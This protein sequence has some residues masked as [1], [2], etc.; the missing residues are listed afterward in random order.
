[1]TFSTLWQPY[2][3]MLHA[4]GINVHGIL[5]NFKFQL[6]IATTYKIIYCHMLTLNT[7]VLPGCKEF[8]LALLLFVFG[9][10]LN[11]LRIST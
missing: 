7:A 10:F 4:F 8:A 5:V 3:P 9:D 2:T 11:S 1:M 6:F